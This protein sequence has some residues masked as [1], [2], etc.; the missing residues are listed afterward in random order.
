MALQGLA[1]QGVD[2]ENCRNQMK[3]GILTFH[4]AHNYGAVLQ[5][6]ALQEILK[7]RGH[8]V[9]VIDYRQPW[10]E[11]FYKY[12]NLRM[13]KMRVKSPAGLLE[14][15]KSDLKKFIISPHRRSYFEDFSNEFLN[16]TLPCSA[17]DIPRDFDCYVI[18]SDQLWSLHCLGGETD[19]VYMGDFSH[20]SGSRVIGYAI[21]ADM[22]SIEAISSGLPQWRRNFDSLSMRESKIAD[23]VAR[24]SGSSCETCLD[25]TLLTDA[26]LWE[27]V[28]DSRWESRKY[29]LVYEVR[30]NKVTRGLLKRK[31]EELAG[32]IGKGCEVIVLSGMRYPVK[33]FVSLFKYAR[34]VVTTSFHGIVFSI[35]FKTPFYALPLWGGY[36]LRYRELLLSLGA[37]DRLVTAE[38]ELLP[39]PMDFTGIHKMLAEKRMASLSFIDKNI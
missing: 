18:G 14:Y 7:R 1:D 20:E 23:M 39:V 31:A 26:D 12:F 2:K 22:K 32:R 27:P 11:D 15:V 33:D 29:V 3:V 5:C 16:T 8:E 17:S 9:Y 13:L 10:I 37:D 34:Y 19:P 36:D 6:Y 30:W 25:P 35:L 21:S 28:I 4:R 38:D 24:I